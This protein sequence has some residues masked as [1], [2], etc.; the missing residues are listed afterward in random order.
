MAF[1]AGRD[2]AIIGVAAL[3]LN[4]AVRKVW[5]M[6]VAAILLYGVTHVL[7]FSIPS[8]FEDLF[9]FDS[10][11]TE[12]C[13]EVN[14]KWDADAEILVDIKSGY[15]A[16]DLEA[17]LADYN[18]SLRPAF[19]K[20]KN[21][22]YSEIDDYF[23]VDVP[24]E[25]LAYVEDI[26][27]SIRNSGMAEGVEMNEMLSATPI[28][29]ENPTANFKTGINTNDPDVSK[30][31]GM[32][33]MKVA[34]LYEWL[35]GKKPVKKAKIAILDTGVEADHEDLAD[36]F[37]SIDSDHDSDKLGHGTHCAGIAAAVSGNGKGIASLAPNTGFVEVTSI[38]VLSDEGSGTQQGIIDGIIQ[39]ADEGADVISLSLGGMSTDDSQR[40]YSEAVKYANK[41]GAIVV[42]AAGNSSDDTHYYAPANSDG[43]IAVTAVGPDMK[44]ASFSNYFEGTIEMGLAAPGVEI[45][46]TY[47]NNGYR[48]LS[49]TSMATPYV[50][51]LLGMM[52]AFN[53]DITTQ[54]AYK[55]LN[56]TGLETPSKASSGAFIQPLAAIQAA[57]K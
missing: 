44:L 23:A 17:H 14:S 12:E 43:I 56:E 8:F 28:I 27:G 5:T 11:Q 39:A 25:K 37:V 34:A 48:F 6:V 24:Q 3:V 51:G 52:K 20:P 18:V 45:Y 41:A 9:N 31:W 57:A 7:H 13:C 38:K 4:R 35:K 10:K 30:Q 22:E 19:T 21:A 33:T 54:E 49:G 15:S 1:S 55:I 36:N 42:A 26:I 50:A 47:P 2:L 46:A 40:A 16:S 53:P 29:E 32:E